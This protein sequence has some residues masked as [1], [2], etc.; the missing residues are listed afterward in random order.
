MPL[1]DT[2]IADIDRRFAAVKPPIPPKLF[3]IRAARGFKLS[4]DM[5]HP[6]QYLGDTGIFRF[7]CLPVNVD[8]VPAAE[9]QRRIEQLPAIIAEAKAK[10]DWSVRSKALKVLHLR[11]MGFYCEDTH[12]AMV[13]NL[14][15]WYGNN[16]RHK[17]FAAEAMAKAKAMP[18][19]DESA[20]ADY[21]A[22]ERAY[23]RAADDLSEQFDE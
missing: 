15:D 6:M 10:G 12:A 16:E 17:Q 20:L 19:D 14:R 3:A 18:P 22:W 1:H 8:I 2:L 23:S 9:H 21:F 13:E 4:A 11:K 7:E 5:Q